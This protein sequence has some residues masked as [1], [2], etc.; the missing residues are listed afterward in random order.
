MT[1]Q[2]A[3]RMVIDLGARTTV[4]DAMDRVRTAPADDEIVLSIATGAPVLRSAVFLE[5]LRR[6]A[7]TRRVAIVTPDA[8][9][10]SLAASVHVPAFGSV[11]AL[12]HHEMDATEPLGPARRAAIAAAEPRRVSRRRAGAV[13]L[14]LFSASLVLAGIVAPTA[15]VVVAPVSQALG[16]L[17]YD[18]RAGPNTA[19]I[20]AQTLGPTP[21]SAK[22]TGTATGSRTEDIRAKG[23]ERF[24]NQTTNSIRIAKGTVVRTADGI[25]FQ[26]TEERLLPASGIVVFPPS[27]QFG[28]VDIAIEA[29]E[30]G[31]KGNVDAKKITV[32]PT[33]GQYTVENPQPTTG[34][35]SK[36]IPVVQLADYD[37]AA[38]RADAELQAQG[39]AQVETW[40]K[41]AT[42][43]RTV[44]G[45]LVRRT[46]LT[47][48][49]DVVG[50]ELAVG[51]T[52][53]DMS[54]SGSATGYSV[55]DTEP[56]ATTLVRLRQAAESGFDID[57]SGAV[58][59]VVG[60]PS[61]RD[62]GVHWRVRGRA[63]QFRRLDEAAIRSALAGRGFEEVSGVVSDR[64]LR[65]VRVSTWPGWWPRLP[66]LD[67]RIQI[68]GEAR[69]ATGSP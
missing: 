17:E 5:V 22:F 44:Y 49:G 39:D 29:I 18:L 21:I 35:D 52:T 56:R 69:A 45:V 36:K 24:T 67:S 26:T 9:A 43:G 63:E 16:P 38:S 37:L 7:G 13:A 62:D 59:E 32:S 42:Q 66:V 57:A 23:S 28:L 41:Q 48:A 19:D 14:S 33:P 4:L 8:R 53:F 68:Q 64:G 12:E 3:G 46:A 25:N 31:P 61:V 51:Q 54:V 6:A 58:V 2:V 20:N 60:A 34:G 11:S 65:L 55:L 27:V 30:A 47:A 15:T 40:R 10:R 50:K 1:V